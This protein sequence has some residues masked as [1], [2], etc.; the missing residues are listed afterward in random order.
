MAR[1]LVI[2]YGGTGCHNILGQLID[3]SS[4][5]KGNK[6]F[7]YGGLRPQL[8]ENTNIYILNIGE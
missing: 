3:H 6:M 4:L 1:L 2:N 7:V 8:E 5:S